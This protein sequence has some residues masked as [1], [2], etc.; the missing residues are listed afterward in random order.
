MKRQ[1]RVYRMNFTE[2]KRVPEFTL[3]LSLEEA[4]SLWHIVNS[5]LKDGNK[6]AKPFVEALYHFAEN[7]NSYSDYLD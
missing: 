7:S 6:N 3:N 5:S 1:E 4:I 2:I